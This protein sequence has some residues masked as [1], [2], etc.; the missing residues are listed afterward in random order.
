MD[1]DMQHVMGIMKEMSNGDKVWMWNGKFHRTD[2]PAVEHANGYRVWYLHGFRHR[3]DG[4]AVELASGYTSWWLN[5][6]V[7]SFDNWLDR[8]TGLT[9]DEKVM[10]KLQYG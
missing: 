6:M 9:E 7:H 1:K 4:P 3:T 5:G 8:T 2:G 10:Y